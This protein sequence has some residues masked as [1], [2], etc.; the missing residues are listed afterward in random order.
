MC[1]PR[2]SL[3]AAQFPGLEIDTNRETC[4]SCG[5]CVAS[6]QVQG[7][8]SL[9]TNDYCTQ[10]PVLSCKRR[11]VAFFTVF[12]GADG[13]IGSRAPGTPLFCEFLPPWVLLKEIQV[14]LANEGLDAI[15]GP[16]LRGNRPTLFWNLMHMCTLHG[17]P[18][19]FLVNPEPEV[20][21]RLVLDEPDGPKLASLLGFPSN[22]VESPVH[23]GL[24]S[25]ATLVTEMDTDSESET[26][27]R[28]TDGNGGR[29]D[30]GK[31]SKRRSS[32]GASLLSPRNTANRLLTPKSRSS[33]RHQARSKSLGSRIEPIPFCST[34]GSPVA[35]SLS[36]TVPSAAKTSPSPRGTR[37]NSG[38]Q[39]LLR[40]MRSPLRVRLG[41]FRL[42]R[43]ATHE[44]GGADG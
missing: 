7:G 5:T 8:W 37:R 35:R 21:A 44:G 41:H 30:F 3:L 17:L 31:H 36:N 43:R 19:D 39:R 34:D 2:G 33:S 10:C 29:R 16:D 25:P 11:F 22:T 4:P 42:A 6:A 26:E 9:D 12:C 15:C 40:A 18:L 28:D 13:W 24:C 32:M 27:G 14:L 20:L 38:S 1:A 23:I